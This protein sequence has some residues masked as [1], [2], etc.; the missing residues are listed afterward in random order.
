MKEKTALLLIAHGSRDADAAR[1]FDRLLAKVR[2]HFPRREISGCFL[3]FNDPALM[4]R[5]QVLYDK[6]WRDFFIQPLTLYEADHT[7]RDI[8]AILADFKES[9]PDAFLCGGGALTPPEMIITAAVEAVQSVQPKGK[10]EDYKL[11]LVGRGAKDRTIADQTINLCRKLHECLDFGDT[12][13][14]YISENAPSYANALVQ[15]AKSHY[16]HVII[17]PWLLFSGRLHKEI[18]RQAHAASENNLGMTFHVTPPLGLQDALAE[19]LVA[20][21]QLSFRSR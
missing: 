2:G 9:H 5:L 18:C 10:I 6:G 12:R 15:A 17:L 13:Y 16:A 14:C 4:D 11:L 3:K 1:D 19:A 21:I 8:P 7:T 20:Q